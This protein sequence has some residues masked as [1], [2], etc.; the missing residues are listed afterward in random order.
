ME[1]NK[2]K[3]IEK[4]ENLV[5][6][7]K[8]EDFKVGDSDEVDDLDYPAGASCCGNFFQHDCTGAE[9]I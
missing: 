6:I 8:M 3:A 5:K 7:M 2:L 1:R 9:V 4:R